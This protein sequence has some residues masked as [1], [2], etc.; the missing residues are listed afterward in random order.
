MDCYVYCTALSFDLK[1]I[2]ENFSSHKKIKKLNSV[3]HLE[4]PEENGDV[5]FFSYGT[6]ACWN[7]SEN[8]RKYLLQEVKSFE[9]NPLEV[10][11]IDIYSYQYGEK[12]SFKDDFIT[13]SDKAVELKEAFSHA[14]AQSAKLSTFET[15]IQQTFNKTHHI[16]QH[17]A[18]YGTIPLSRREI[19]KQIGQIFIDRSSINLNLDVL[20]SPNFF[21]DHAAYEPLYLNMSNQLDLV[22]RTEAINQQLSVLHEL[23]D[24]LGIELKDQH[25]HRLE[26]AIIYLIIIEVALLF[27]HDVLKLI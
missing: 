22:K 24:M 5:F 1:K 19:R 16:P 8:K 11:E 23:F 18:K 27:L 7:L 9:N 6:V 2:L 15:T 3:I 17:L 26:W 25:S 4:F 21:W 14:L 20:D 10:H 12:D 13:L